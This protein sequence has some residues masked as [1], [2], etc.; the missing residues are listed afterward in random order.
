M[1]IYVFILTSTCSLLMLTRNTYK[2]QQRCIAFAYVFVITAFAALRGYVGTDTYSYHLLFDE[3]Q[4]EDFLEIIKFTEPIFAALVK[5]SAAI[6]KNS[7]VFTILISILQ[8]GILL[9]LTKNAR[10]PADLLAIYIATFFITFEF[11]ILRAGTA[12]LLLLLAMQ[13]SNSED[14]RAFYFFGISSVF[15]HYSAVIG[16]LPMLFL[17]SKSKAVVLLLIIPVFAILAYALVSPTQYDQYLGYLDALSVERDVDYGMGFVASLVLYALLYISALNKSNFTK[18][19]ALFFAWI[20]IRWASNLFLFVD[21]IEVIINAIL[22]FLIAESEL[23]GWRRQVHNVA[24]VALISLSL[25]GTL[26]GLEQ[27]DK[28]SRA[29]I[30][31]VNYF[32]SPYV[33]YKFIWEN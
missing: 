4:A 21:R 15:A 22:L 2:N 25:Y 11:N 23:I 12:I 8:G 1:L 28:G 17:K 24:L 9:R 7:F 10:R 3:Y 32:M 18:L 33:P 6:S 16:F 5:I 14:K 26:M 13:E 31:N 20:S 19:S 30:L 29:S 27:A